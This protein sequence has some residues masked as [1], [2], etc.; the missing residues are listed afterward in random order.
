MANKNIEQFIATYG[1]VAQQVSKEIN[2][3]PNVLLSQWGL[4]S[5][6]GQTEMAKKYH[7]LGGIKDFSGA[8]FEAKDNKTGSKDKYVK[9]EDPEVFGMY[10]V[11]QIKRNFPNALNTG[12]DAGAFTRG[13]ASG[14]KG[15]YFEVPIEEYEKSLSSAQASIPESKMLPFEPTVQPK[16]K[17]AQSDGNIPLVDAPPPPPPPPPASDKSNASP[18][19]KFLY[20]GAGA[21][22]GTIA[23]GKNAYDVQKT[24]TLAKRAG[25]EERA[26]I[27]AQRSA[28][29]VPPAAPSVPTTVP[30]TTPPLGSTIMRQTPPATGGLTP[31]M[32]PADAGRMPKGQTGV[33]PY[34]TAK[35]LGLTDIEAAQA[36]TNTKQE[37]GAWDLSNKRGEAMSKLRGMGITNYA[38]NP[39]YGGIL[40]EQQGVGGGPRESF[41]M[42]ASV[43]PSPDLPQGQAGGLSQLPPRQIVPTTPPPPTTGMR[44]KAGLDWITGKFANMMQPVVG[45]AGTVGKVVLPP[46]G[47]LSA[48]LDVADIAHEYRKP[49]DQRDLVKMGLKGAGVL[50]GVMS[51]FPVTAPVGIPLSIGTAAA[52]TYREDPEYFKEKMKEYTG[53]SP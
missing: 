1:P 31:P 19:E 48:G 5:R 16:E 32:G 21:A 46:L 25:L 47:G 7:N 20:G 23:A 50:G 34:N 49:V 35:A 13:L 36:L 43:A 8:G 27:A 53:Y 12:P 6:W 38:E 11:D 52:Q 45:A 4:E 44:A 26:R 29:V 30:A 18:S 14:K 9:F 3:D 2:V 24:A 41:T 10:Y 39:M 22:T 51:M 17:L 15:S 40:T 42:K 37:G 33:I 28:G